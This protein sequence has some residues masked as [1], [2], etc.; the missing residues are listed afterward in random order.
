MDREELLQLLEEARAALASGRDSRAI[1]RRIEELTDGAFPGIMS[2]TLAVDPDVQAEEEFADALQAVAEVSPAQNFFEGLGQGLT[3]GGLDELV[4]LISPEAGE[5]LRRRQ[6]AREI[7]NP[8]T[9]LALEVGGAAVSP[10]TR[11]L[12]AGFQALRG[13]GGLIRST[14]AA[15]ATGGAGGGAFGFLSAEGDVGERARAA[16][17][18]AALGAGLGLAGPLLVAGGR[19]VGRALAPLTRTTRAGARDVTRTAIEGAGMT[20]DEAIEGVRQG[21][22]LALQDPSIMARAPGTVRTAPNLRR[23]GGPVQN[24]RA[25]VAPEQVRAA[26][27]AI[28]EPLEEV[29]VNDRA[30]ISAVR[31]NPRIID[32]ATKT[33][34]GLRVN[35][36]DDLGSLTFREV[37]QIRGR[38]K[39]A[40]KKAMRKGDAGLAE[41]DQATGALAEFDQAIDVALPAFR[42]ARR[43]FAEVASRQEAAGQLFAALETAVPKGAPATGLPGSIEGVGASLRNAVFNL[44]ARKEAIAEVFGEMILKS[45]ESAARELERLLRGGFITRSLSRSVRDVGLPRSTDVPFGAIS[46]VGQLFGADVSP[47]GGGGGLFEEF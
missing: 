31:R 24:L 29:V 7:T 22:P 16:G 4:G 40:V 28:F 18:E 17:P 42:A 38:L 44:D 23:I 9:S 47:S 19:S 37:Q 12:G 35:N 6:E 14:G 20:V 43:Q 34:P 2:L 26:R 5:A 45:G 33:V 8:K 13:G 11:A 41:F 27:R 30:V 10:V 21:N 32:A 15:A 3:F 46:G 36:L 1:N 39:D 25:S